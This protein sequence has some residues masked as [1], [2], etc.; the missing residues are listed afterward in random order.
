MIFKEKICLREFVLPIQNYP[1]TLA[2]MRCMDYISSIQ[3]KINF[4]E[5]LVNNLYV[6]SRTGKYT[7]KS[8]TV[9]QE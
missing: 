2:Y 4:L 9:V 8:T 5:L 6:K 1:Y 3:Y 7:K